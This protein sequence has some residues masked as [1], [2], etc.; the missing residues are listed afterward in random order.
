MLK[1]T[2]DVLIGFQNIT[3]AHKSR[4]ALGSFDSVLRCVF[5]VMDHRLGQNVARTTRWH[6]GAA[7]LVTNVFISFWRLLWFIT[8][9]THDTK[10][11]ML[12]MV[13]SSIRLSPNR[14]QVRTDQNTGTIQSCLLWIFQLKIQAPQ[15][16][17][18]CVV[19]LY[20]SVPL[21]GCKKFYLWTTSLDCKYL[22]PSATSLW[23]G[24]FLQV[25]F[26]AKKLSKKSF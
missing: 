12:L 19:I 4:N 17:S 26:E 14:S 18:S 23:N 6:T 24:T 2:C 5:S 11:K 15:N 10:K 22:I 9:Q 3:Y 25:N 8:V 7:E 16:L 13:T 20:L 1:A 21:V